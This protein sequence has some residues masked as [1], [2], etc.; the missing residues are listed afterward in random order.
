MNDIPSIQFKSIGLSIN[1]D[2]I[3]INTIDSS[4]IINN[5]TYYSEEFVNNIVTNNNNISI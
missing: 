5:R 2:R 1:G 4:A 3:P